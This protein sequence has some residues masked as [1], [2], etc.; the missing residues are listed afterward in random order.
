[1][2]SYQVNSTNGTSNLEIVHSNQDLIMEK[3]HGKNKILFISLA[4]GIVIVAAVIVILVIFLKNKGDS[5]AD[6][7]DFAITLEEILYGSLAA[8]GFNATWI[9]GSELFFRSSEGDVLLYNVETATTRTLLSGNSSVLATAFD[10]FLSPDRNYLLI[11]HDY[12]KLYRYSFLAQYT[13]VNLLNQQTKLVNVSGES[14]LQLA[15]WG[16]V[17]NSLIFIM[18]NN[19]YYR[20]SAASEEDT[21][22][23]TDGSIGNVYNGVPD[24]VYEEE[25]FSSNKAFWFSP[26]G[27]KLAYAKF[28][29]RN[30]PLM[31]IP[32]YGLPGDLNFQYTRAVQIRYPKAGTVNPTVT[33]HVVNLQNQFSQLILSP[34][35]ALRNVDNILATVNW[36]TNTTVTAIWMNRVQNYAEILAYVISDTVATSETI[37]SINKTNGWIELFTPPLFSDDGTKMAVILS[38]DQGNNLGGYRHIT[39]FNVNQTSSANVITNG[40]FV[41]GEILSWDSNNNLIYYTSNTEEDPAVQHVYSVSTVSKNRTCLSCNTDQSSLSTDCLYNSADFSLDHTHFALKC[42]GPGVPQISIFRTNNQHVTDWTNGD[43]LKSKL[44]NKSIPTIKQMSFEVAG[45]FVAQVL[46]K[47]PPNLDTSGNVKYPMVVHVYGGPDS[48][49]VIKK[50][51]MDWG[52]YLAS[53]KSIIYAMIDG[54]GSGLKGDKMLF[55]LYRALGTVEVS[56]QINVTRQI[57]LSLPYV[58]SSKTAIWGWSYGGYASAM[59][60]AKDVDGVFKCGM[61]VAPVT[62]WTLY[63]SVYTERFMGLPLPGDNSE[64]YKNSLLLSQ[65]E[66]IRKKDYFLIHGTLDDNV[67]YQQSMLWA[68]V[69]EQQDILFRQLSY[70][71]EDHGLATIRPH[72]YHSLENFLNECFLL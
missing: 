12:Q 26:D 31:T 35:D 10:Y 54:R 28:D 50:Y 70:P 39:L 34:P 21:Q 43:E 66:G 71:D 8:S 48:Y 69:L 56:D 38:Q 16:P 52:S 47:L 27:T 60:L 61:S 17:G 7:Q 20:A 30:V 37:V 42:E 3:R 14:I 44:R 24:W 23:T 9:S 46:L 13:I 5:N 53:N 57:Q 11:G 51:S 40:K 41:V 25:V 18:R 4:V 58:D 45:G 1:M 32:V 68:K 33:F 62:D 67:H 63:D 22:I 36:A 55:S 15:S 72:L 2:T 64:G 49:Q 6:N 29:D 65:Y 19:I 59:A